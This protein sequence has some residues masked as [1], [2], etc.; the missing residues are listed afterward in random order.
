MRPEFCQ[1]PLEPPPAGTASPGPSLA[2]KDE[3]KLETLKVSR[4]KRRSGLGPQEQP[5]GDGTSSLTLVLT[6]FPALPLTLSCSLSFHLG[7]LYLPKDRKGETC[8]ERTVSY[9]N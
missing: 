4:H 6:L 7:T 5:Q 8:K 9:R 1:P 3:I 2:E